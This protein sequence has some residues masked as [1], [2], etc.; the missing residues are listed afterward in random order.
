M[1]LRKCSQRYTM[2]Q[3]AMDWAASPCHVLKQPPPP[4]PPAVTG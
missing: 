3:S 1:S 4:P 2:Q